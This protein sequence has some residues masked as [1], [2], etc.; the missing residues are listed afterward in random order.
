MSTNHLQLLVHAT[1]VGAFM[2]AID[3]AKMSDRMV[4]GASRIAGASDRSD[5]PASSWRRQPR[6]A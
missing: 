3:R 5:G 2:Q 6:T 4:A 1:T